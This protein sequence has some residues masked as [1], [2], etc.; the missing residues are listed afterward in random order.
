MHCASVPSA[1]QSHGRPG[2]ISTVL[3]ELPQESTEQPD[4]SPA[5]ICNTAWYL[6]PVTGIQREAIRLVHC[7]GLNRSLILAYIFT[8]CRV[9]FSSRI[10]QTMPIESVYPQKSY[11][12]N[13]YCKIQLNY[14]KLNQMWQTSDH[15]KVFAFFKL[16][17]C[18]GFVKTRAVLF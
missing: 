1:T 3:T 4:A 9:I 17:V 2:G 12:E 10:N 6:H 13:I 18:S 5:K 8:M 7:I 15:T 11:A 16:Y 14:F